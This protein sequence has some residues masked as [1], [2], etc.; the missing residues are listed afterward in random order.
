MLNEFS[1]KCPAFSADG[2]PFKEIKEENTTIAFALE[3]CPAFV[4]GECPFSSCT[5]VEEVFD[6]FGKLPPRHAGL[7]EVPEL[8]KMMHECSAALRRETGLQE[9]PIFSL[10]SANGCPFKNLTV[11]GKTLVDELERATWA[12]TLLARAPA[13]SEMSPQLSKQLKEGTKETHKEAENVHFVR[14]FIKGHVPRSVCKVILSDLYH[15]YVALE[16]AADA[17]RDDNHFGAIHFPEE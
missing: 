4:Q 10:T 7:P 1:T 14:E 15:V 9:C 16:A 11:G 3:K 12:Q 13:N 6:V 5:S 2:C 17:C 8:L